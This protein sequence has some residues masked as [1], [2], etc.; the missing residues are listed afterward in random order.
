MLYLSIGNKYLKL[1]HISERKFRLIL[2]YF[3]SD[4][5]ATTTSKLT[6]IS[7]NSINKIFLQIRV[8]ISEICEEDSIFQ[9]GEIEV[10]ESYFGARGV[11]GK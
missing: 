4:I 2:L 7:R 11:K 3:C 9:T 8:R 6:G 10:D 5:N 1:S